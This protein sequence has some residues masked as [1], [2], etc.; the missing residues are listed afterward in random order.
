M[1]V[2]STIETWLLIE[3]ILEYNIHKHYADEIITH[4][5]INKFNSIK[6]NHYIGV[7]ET[8]P[9]HHTHPMDPLSIL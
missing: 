5:C 2:I 3:L 8:N 4:H 9:T 7:V 1:I 6:L